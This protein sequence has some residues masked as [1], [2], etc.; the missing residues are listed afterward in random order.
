MKWYL[1]AAPKEN[2]G[3]GSFN[4]KFVTEILDKSKT[5]LY[6]YKSNGIP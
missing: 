2:A 5:F 4:V 1:L 3:F 6:G